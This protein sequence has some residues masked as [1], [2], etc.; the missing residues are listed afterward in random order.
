MLTRRTSAKGGKQTSGPNEPRHAIVG[1]MPLYTLVKALATATGLLVALPSPSHAQA[2][3]GAKEDPWLARRDW[4]VPYRLS[5]HFSTVLFSRDEHRGSLFWQVEMRTRGNRVAQEPYKTHQWIDGRSCPAVEEVLKKLS[6]V[7]VGFGVPGNMD[8][9]TMVFDGG[10]IVLAGPGPAFGASGQ[11][12]TLSQLLGPL[13]DWWGQ[14]LQ[15]LK[16]CW[17]DRPERLDGVVLRT[18]MST[19]EAEQ[20]EKP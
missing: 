6:A 2:P 11:M 16:S 17:V 14:G 5:T 18:R 3:R 19:D 9:T 4:D 10:K 1:A 12:V 20:A 8:E 7:P 15:D 13:W